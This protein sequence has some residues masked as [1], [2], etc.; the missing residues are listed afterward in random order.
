MKLMK[1]YEPAMCC[2]TGVCGPSVDLELLRITA[3][4]NQI[5]QSEKLIERLNLT[6]NPMAFVEA[7]EV[8]EL[9]NE[10][11]TEI[12]PITVFDG[13]IVKTGAYP[14]NEEIEKYLGVKIQNE[15]TTNSSC[16]CDNGCC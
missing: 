14:T 7:T 5:N 4:T 12:L 15:E 8:N 11:G 13:E 10:K 16:C 1:I 9:L 3:I 2:S 6:D